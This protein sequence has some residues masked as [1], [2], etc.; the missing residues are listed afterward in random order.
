MVENQTGRK[1]KVLRFDNGG[2]YTSTEFKAYLPGEGIKHRLGISGRSE[3]NELAK[4]MNQ[5][6]TERAC[7]IRFRLT[8]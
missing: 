4:R 2:E 8:C 1:V 7:S 3:Q 5:T 6:L